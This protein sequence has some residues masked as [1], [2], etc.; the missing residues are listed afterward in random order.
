M[1]QPKDLPGDQKMSNKKEELSESPDPRSQGDAGTQGARARSAD[2]TSAATSTAP[3][4]RKDRTRRSP[5]APTGPFHIPAHRGGRNPLANWDPMESGSDDEQTERPKQG[6][7][8]FPLESLKGKSEDEKNEIIRNLN[9]KIETQMSAY[10]EKIRVI[11][12]VS[13][14]WQHRQLM[15]LRFAEPGSHQLCWLKRMWFSNQSQTI[16]ILAHPGRKYRKYR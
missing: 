6:I 16:Q 10:E 2:A 8:P 9:S 13:Y 15:M 4:I 3:R 12:Q 11:E 1:I 7:T 5:T 14:Q